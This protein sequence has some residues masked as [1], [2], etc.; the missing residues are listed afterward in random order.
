MSGNDGRVNGKNEGIGDL[1]RRDFLKR[2]SFA[3]AGM[4]AFG[5]LGASARAAEP[6]T[7]NGLPA[8]VLGRTGLKVTKIS[9]GGILAAEPALVMQAI[10]RGF[11]LVHTCTGYFNGRSIESVGEAMKTRRDK[12]ILGL[13]VTVKE[14]GYMEKMVEDALKTLNT[15]HI[16][17][18]FP[19]ID[20]LEV[21]KSP[22]IPEKFERIK[23]AGKARFLGFSCHATVPTL[24]AARESGWY[25]VTL[26][27]YSRADDPKFL[28]AV[29]AANQA[30]IGILAMKGLPKP[31]SRSRESADINTMAALSSAMVNRQ[32]A[33]T[34]LATMGSVQMIDL[35]RE[36]LE[37]HIA[38]ED[39][40]LESRYWAEQ[41]G[42]YCG[43]CRECTKVCPRSVDIP[44]VVRYKMY[45]D[46]Y[47][48]RDYARGRYSMLAAGC[49]GTSCIDCGKCES[50]CSRQLPIRD[51]LKETH[52]SL[53]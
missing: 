36:V 10:D 18:L 31:I 6:L 38:Y 49:N 22:E 19:E 7:V 29:K 32:H 21:M 17:I 30:G 15:D 37:K 53:G 5:S 47:G 28:E 4:A 25:D 40:N 24:N 16:D 8:T 52:F 2:A 12:V 43:M 34:V 41:V 27:A 26:M 48:M 46:S 50:V 3:A 51:I 39:R 45:E 35:Y 20:K 23:E 9:H 13:K 11:N 1:S 14:I 33:H 44:R 42:Y